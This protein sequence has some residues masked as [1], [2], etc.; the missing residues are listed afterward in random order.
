MGHQQMTGAQ[1]E[2]AEARLFA[3]IADRYP[4]WTVYTVFGGY[5]AVPD[6]V[7][8]VRAMNLERLLEKLA[9]Q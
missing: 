7:T 4:G 9:E 5:E 3:E 2:Q 1:R 6:G 8:V